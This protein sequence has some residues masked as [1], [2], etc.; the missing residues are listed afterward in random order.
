METN[1]RDMELLRLGFNQG[2]KCTEMHP[3]DDDY[4]R[5]FFNRAI[6][7]A[8]NLPIYHVS[9][10]LP[11]GEL[12]DFCNRSEDFYNDDEY[13]DDANKFYNTALNDIKYWAK[14]ECEGD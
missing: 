11:L 6:D 3:D 1:Q 5:I 8:E 13:S 12:N 9:G 2:I 4:D 7:E 14:K 10:M